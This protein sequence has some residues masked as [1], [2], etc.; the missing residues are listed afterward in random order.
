MEDTCSDDD[1]KYKA[2]VGI[3]KDIIDKRFT[4]E[5]TKNFYN[6]IIDVDPLAHLSLDEMM[7]QSRVIGPVEQT[8]HTYAKDLVEE[9]I[10]KDKDFLSRELMDKKEIIRKLAEAKQPDVIQVEETEE[11]DEIED[12]E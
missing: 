11:V 7:T 6:T 2:M 12:M 3:Q 5:T 9:A 4:D 10:S 1:E 8:I